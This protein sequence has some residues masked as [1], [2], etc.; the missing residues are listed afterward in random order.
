V[1]VLDRAGI[2][3]DDGP[4]HHGV[5]DLAQTLSIPGMTVF[6]PSSA[7]DVGPM[8]ETALELD[9]PASIRMPK[10]PARHVPADEVG[11]GLEAKALREGD[12]TVCLLGVG[13]LVAACLQAADELAAE[14]I[15]AT[16]WDVRVVS[17]PDPAMIADAARH[18]LVVSAEDGIRV[19]GAGTFLGQAIEAAGRRVGRTT[20]PIRVLGI[21]RAYVPA[22]RPDDILAGLGL[23]GAGVALSVRELLG[24]TSGQLTP[25]GGTPVRRP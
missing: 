4:S 11:R 2:T 23:D 7:E 10:T 24:L 20:P 22:G 12:G 17:P 8:L 16:V 6:A 19:G 25:P 1:V 9:G 5:L 21:P 14:G 13:K 3:G 18:R 15:R